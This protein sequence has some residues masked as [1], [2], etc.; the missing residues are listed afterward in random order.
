[1]VKVS[2]FKINPV[3]MND[4]ETNICKPKTPYLGCFGY[5]FMQT[6]K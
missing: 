1:M 6:T 3:K 4:F 2:N 5:C